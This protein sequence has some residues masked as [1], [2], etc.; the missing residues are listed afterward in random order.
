MERFDRRYLHR[1][2]RLA[3]ELEMGTISPVECQDLAVGCRRMANALVALAVAVAD[4]TAWIPD[5]PP[6]EP[7]ERE[8]RP[9]ADVIRID[10]RG[11]R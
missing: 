8:A 4:G 5:A 3:A 9:L 10:E 1:L 2:T 11:R 6:P 7:P